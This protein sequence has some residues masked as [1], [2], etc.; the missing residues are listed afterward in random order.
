VVAAGIAWDHVVAG[1]NTVD[2]ARTLGSG[3]CCE[4]AVGIVVGGIT[5]LDIEPDM[6]EWGGKRGTGTPSVGT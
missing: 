5:L 4:A 6:E 3:N 1:L 2:I